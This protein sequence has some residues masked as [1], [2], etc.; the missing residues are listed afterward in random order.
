MNQ[1]SFSPALAEDYSDIIVRKVQ[2]SSVSDQMASSSLA[3]LADLAAKSASLL[4]Q[5]VNEEYSIVY[6]PLSDHLSTVEEIGYSSVPKLFTEINVVS[7]EA[8][9]ILSARIQSFLNLSGA[10]VLMGFLDSGIDYTHPAFRNDDGTSRILRLWDQ[11][12][13]RGT[14]PAGLSYGTEYTKDMIDRT[15][16]SGSIASFPENNEAIECEAF[17][18]KTEIVPAPAPYLD[19]RGHGT[20]VAGIACGSP[21][22]GEGFTGAAP[23]CSIA[24]VRL[25]SAKQYLRSYFR[26]PENAVAYQENDL[27]LGIRYLTDCAAQLGMPLVICVSLGTNQ[28]GH[29][30]QTPLEKTLDAAL[31]TPGINAVTGTGNE[32]GL[33]HHYR[34]TPLRMGDVTEAE[35]LIGQETQGF[36]LE[37]WAAKPELYRLGFTSPLGETISPILPANGFSRD[38]SFLLETSQITITWGNTGPFDGDQVILMRFQNPTPG[39]WRI[40]IVSSAPSNG[41][42]HLWLPIHGFVDPQI[43]FLTP[44]ADTTLVI[45]SCAMSPVSAGT[46]N[47][48]NNSLFLHSGRGYT[49]NGIV[50]PDF[51][52]P[53]V[54]V[55]CPAAGGS[56]T[57]ITGSCAAAAVTAGA[58]ALLFEIGLR[59]NPPRYFFAEELKNLF[60]RGVRQR[61]SL[62]YPNQNWGNGE[63]NLSGIFQS[64]P[65]H[66]SSGNI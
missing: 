43:R 56:Y 42:F 47:A 27:M 60:L 37:F 33:D 34:G 46:W 48:Y 39:I 22:A 51:V 7:L 29:T 41:F 1:S 11:S 31:R 49:R 15:L 18:A 63:M 24:F 23:M 20:A 13:T 65:S 26:I 52:S 45:P 12:D 10:G 16:F 38:F 50:K 30:G 21:D 2:F 59:Q 17:P 8:S 58:A 6:A 3:D 4:S 62:A 5:E 9:G 54:Q 44:D 64:F 57:S 66:F 25:K 19:S 36:S 35:L 53:G 40:R 61:G 32:V 55:T 14:P 28:G